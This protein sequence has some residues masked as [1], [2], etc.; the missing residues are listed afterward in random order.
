MTKR[1][2]IWLHL[3]GLLWKLLLPFL[4]K[5]TRLKIGLEERMLKILPQ[6]CDIWI[7]AAS[8]GEA[9]LV[10]SLLSVWSEKYDSPIRILCTS[11]TSQGKDILQKTRERLAKENTAMQIQVWAFPFDSPKNMRQ[12]LEHINVKLL[13]LMETE[14]WPSLLFFAK[15]KNIPVI[16]LNGRVRKKTCSRYLRIKNILKS[17]APTKILASS[18]QSVENFKQIFPQ[19]TV[20][21]CSN[22]KFDRAI[23]SKKTEL[24]DDI[25]SSENFLVFGSIRKEEEDIILETIQEL[26]QKYPTYCIALFPRHMKRIE[27]LE[28]KLKKM[29]LCFTLR[30]SLVKNR[31]E[32][33]DENSN[34]RNNKKNIEKILLWDTFGE[35]QNAY[36]KAKISFV[37]GSLKA[38]GGQNFLEPLAHGSYTVVGEHRENFLWIDSAFFDEKIA[39][40]VSNKETLVAAFSQILEIS[41]EENLTKEQIAAIFTN[42]IKTKQGGTLQSVQAALSLLDTQLNTKIT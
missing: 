23:T 34:E 39:F 27:H 31:T 17:I 4:K 21:F 33:C 32:Q 22:I 14:L 5:N 2:P 13:I 3:Y 20:S 26:Q 6:P 15:K 8:A 29:N 36:A 30:S 42:I 11:M 19:T 38:L 41:S 16:M 37:G 10:D 35:L 18:E 7:Q 24:L 1:F 40:E 12:F 28:K 25:I 9:Y